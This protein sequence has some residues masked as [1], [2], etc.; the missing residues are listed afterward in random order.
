MMS[1]RRIRVIAL[2]ILIVIACAALL[3]WEL[4]YEQTLNDK[5][6]TKRTLE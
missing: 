5:F 4:V 3:G 2:I 1:P 6:V